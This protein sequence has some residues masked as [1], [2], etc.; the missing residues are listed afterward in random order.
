MC[1]VNIRPLLKYIF[2][3]NL[4]GIIEKL[5]MI[6]K[7]YCHLKHIH[8]F[9]HTY[10]HSAITSK[11]FPTIFLTKKIIGCSTTINHKRNDS[12]INKMIK[13]RKI[14]IMNIKRNMQHTE[15][16]YFAMRPYT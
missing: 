2:P 9:M 8:I 14:K 5:C 7:I 4:I 1:Y 16:V 10:V 3:Y 11:N 12:N 13:K 6:L 15:L